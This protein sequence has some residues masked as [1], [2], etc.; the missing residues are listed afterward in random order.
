MYEVY[1]E[2]AGMVKCFNEKHEALE[3]FEKLVRM[4]KGRVD[5]WKFDWWYEIWDS[6]K[7]IYWK[8]LLPSK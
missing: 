6:W 1:D 7:K 4:F 5:L 8:E 3:Y 2:V